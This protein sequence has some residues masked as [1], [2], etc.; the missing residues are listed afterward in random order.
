MGDTFPF[1][2]LFV[3][4]C[5]INAEASIQSL[6]TDCDDRSCARLAA[7]VACYAKCG[8]HPNPFNL[9]GGADQVGWGEL[10]PSCANKIK[11]MPIIAL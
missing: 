11:G 3:A 10:I 5:L 7:H 4:D 2:H 9:P 8:F 6:L 1:R